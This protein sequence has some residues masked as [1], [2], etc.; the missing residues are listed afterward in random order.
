MLIHQFNRYYE[1]KVSDITEH[2]ITASEDGNEP[3]IHEMRVG[4]KKLRA[5]S[6]LVKG[7]DPKY[8]L[9]KAFEPIRK[10]F[11]SAAGIR[12]AQ[13]IQAL[14][15]EHISKAGLN[16]N[17]SEYFNLL[18]QKEMLAKKGFFRFCKTYDMAVF[19]RNRNLI[20]KRLSNIGETEIEENSRKYLKNLLD[21]IN[22]LKMKNSLE[23]K[24]FHDIR[25]LCK[26]A[27]YT[28]EILSGCYS[29]EESDRLNNRLR[30]IHQAL[31]QWHDTDVAISFLSEVLSD[32]SLKPLFSESS[33]A[34]VLKS[35]EERK[36]QFSD[37]FYER[38]DFS[39][40]N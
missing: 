40:L 18:K 14:A 27:R 37:L 5:F 8:N 23:E 17:I 16:V 30:S 28:L 12:D 29:Q 39:D 21:I 36:Q 1:A 11:K 4:I 3:A 32:R 22:D 25:I 15:R 31:G 26:K 7:L 19:S 34:D 35:L 38:F 2:F 24:D 20:N 10:L 9:K 33:Y 13:V 6:D